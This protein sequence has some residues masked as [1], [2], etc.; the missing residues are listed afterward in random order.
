MARPQHGGKR[1]RGGE[2]RGQKKKQWRAADT[3][4]TGHGIFMTCPRGKERKAANELIE[5]LTDTAASLY[6][7]LDL[8]QLPI[9]I[10]PPKAVDANV[11]DGDDDDL[12]NGPTLPAAGT[13]PVEAIPSTS[14]QETRQAEAS[15]SKLPEPA[16]IEQVAPT[17][18]ATSIED[19]LRAELASL[20]E[21]D[22]KTFGKRKAPQQQGKGQEGGEGGQE[23]PATAPAFR[24][25]ETGTECLV[26]IGVHHV[27]DPF[28]L[29]DTFLSEVER[30]GEARSRIISRL[31]PVAGLCLAN[32]QELDLFARK[33]LP[34]FFPADGAGTFKIDP[35]I[36]S[37]NTLSRTEVIELTAQAIP[38]SPAGGGGGG[39]WRA[40]LKKAEKWV[41][42]EIHKAQ[43]GIGVLSNYVRFCKMNPL[44]LA[45]S[46]K[47][48]RLEGQDGGGKGAQAVQESAAAGGE[49]VPKTEERDRPAA[50]T[51]API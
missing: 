4:W 10:R 18:K 28:D 9:P 50:E 20:R 30:T 37:H 38:R 8:S 1:K 17:A 46:I 25:M 44:E 3:N 39:G 35:R 34:R 26:F 16:K 27:L 32:H 6:P 36:R 24:L 19:E 43:A 23:K 5:I 11:D 49:E 7:N 51:A 45:N 48:K 21:A 47:T 41:V 15:S 14:S 22:S 12:R 31:S 29:C 2:E 33:V 13:S 40:D 42:V